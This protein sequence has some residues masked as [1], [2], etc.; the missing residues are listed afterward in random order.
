M[1]ITKGKVVNGQVV[2][3][4]ESLNEGAVVTILVSDERTFTLTDEEEAALL[5]SIT[6]ADRGDLLD[7]EDVLRRLP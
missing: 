7:A 1:R 2:V 3:E 6:E 4:G 5:Q